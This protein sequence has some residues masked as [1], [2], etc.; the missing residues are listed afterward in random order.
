MITFISKTRANLAKLLQD[1]ES[2]TLKPQEMNPNYPA[3]ILVLTSDIDKPLLQFFIAFITYLLKEEK[4][5]G[6][7]KFSWF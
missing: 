6:F 1:S 2:A 7:R 5:T 4:N 3:T